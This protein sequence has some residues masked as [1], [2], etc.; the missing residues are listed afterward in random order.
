MGFK[1][2]GS[3]LGC[4]L[5]ASLLLASC[6]PDG[7][8]QYGTSADSTLSESEKGGESTAFLDT[9]VT[10][11]EITTIFIS[12]SDPE[13]TEIAGTTQTETISGGGRRRQRPV[14]S[15]RLP[16]RSM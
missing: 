7:G 9:S 8:H 11:G 15:I 5:A 6:T 16:L 3:I 14:V 2:K 4:I 1:L 13:T 12:T 10:V